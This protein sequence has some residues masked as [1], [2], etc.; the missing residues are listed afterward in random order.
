MERAEP[1]IC[2]RCEGLTELRGKSRT[3]YCRN[4]HQFVIDGTLGEC[5]ARD[6][7]GNEDGAPARR[8][9]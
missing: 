3:A 9:G 7:S 2:P 5:R 1:P 6:E 4:C 8:R